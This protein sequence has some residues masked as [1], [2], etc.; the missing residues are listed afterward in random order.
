MKPK[1]QV[2]SATAHTSHSAVL[3]HTKGYVKHH[4]EPIF[5]NFVNCKA[6]HKCLKFLVAINNT[7]K[8]PNIVPPKVHKKCGKC[9]NTR[10]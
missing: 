7:L 9:V 1:V 10:F 3:L 2:K 8:A 4:F 5:L 6:L